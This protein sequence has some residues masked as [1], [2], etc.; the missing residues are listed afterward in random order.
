MHIPDAVLDP[1]VAAATGVVAAAG[2]SAGLR[3][4]E[5]RLG[6]RTT[7]LMGTMAAFV[8]AAQM[9]NF[10][11]GPLPISGHLL[12]GV[13]SA[14]MLGPWAGAVVIG[15]VLIV[16]CLLFGDGGLTALGA[17]FLNMGLIGAVG[18]YAIY[19]PIR[20]AIGGRAGVLL[21][22]MVAAWFSVILASGAFAIE[23]AF[24]SGWANFFQTLSWM[25]LVHAGIGL[26][27][28]LVTGLVIRFI[29]LTRPDLVYQAD[30]TEASAPGWGA[31]ICAGL[32]IALAVCVF[33]A[34][35]ASEHPDGLEYVG[36]K[37]GFLKE[38]VPAMIPAPIP[39]YS[40][41]LL[42]DA[43]VKA[44]TAFAGLVGTLV[45]FAVG[46]GLARVFSTTKPTGVDPDAA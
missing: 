24:S 25:A 31:L 1:K 36:E 45:V 5:S 6:E 38:G 16:Q 12:G 32:G 20:R 30:E 15:A 3:L 34:P 19:A 10:P 23:L 7:V 26:G 11:I 9:V 46:L 18:G 35:F 37:L 22:A 2:M 21:G 39:D 13:L 40:L 28:A 8:F 33:L 27:E 41:P 14:V 42:G 17:N 4:L 43:N 29:L 44:A